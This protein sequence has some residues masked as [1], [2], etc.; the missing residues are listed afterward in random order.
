MYEIVE[1]FG[2]R[3]V[4]LAVLESAAGELARLGG[5]YI[6][7]CRKCCEQRGQHGASTMHMKLGNVFAGR[8]SRPRKPEHNRVVDSLIHRVTQ[9]RTR[10]D[11]GRR[12]FPGEFFQREPGLWT[13][14]ANDRDRTRRTAGRQCEDGLL[15]RMHGL[16]EPLA[17]K[18]QCPQTSTCNNL[19]LQCSILKYCV[20]AAA[21]A[22]KKR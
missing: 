10:C 9:Q 15:S 8:A 21:T 19:M 3:E 17:S 5:A 11:S 18:R 7:D 2:L 13:G 6:F 4:D 14:Q 22:Q 1:T 20:L 12:N 16:I